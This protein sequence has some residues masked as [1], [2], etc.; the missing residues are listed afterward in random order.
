M[1]GEQLVGNNIFI[2][3]KSSTKLQ[4]IIPDPEST[5]IIQIPNFKFS[6]KTTTNSNHNNNFRSAIGASYSRTTYLNVK[7]EH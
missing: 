7:N 1:G 6:S 5:M 4:S 3:K 2:L